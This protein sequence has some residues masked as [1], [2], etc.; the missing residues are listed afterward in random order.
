MLLLGVLSLEGTALYFQ[1]V[2]ELAPCVM[3]IY[4][5]VALFG[6]GLAAIVALLAPR[7]ILFRVTG[8][9]LGIYS[10]VRGFLLAMQHT[11]YQQNPAPWNQCPI[12]VSFPSSFPLNK[13]LPS[14]FQP[15]GACDKIQWQFLSLSMP[16]WLMI[17][18]AFFAVV[19]FMA[20]ISQFAK[21][22][23]KYK[24]PTFR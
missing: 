22:E 1:H 16:Q 18:F 17:I 6:I 24:G 10:A 7:F 23:T 9:L 2:M 14:V 3:C 5:R 19:L 15:T 20:L 12:T 8:L 21:T 13:W 4:E 11:D